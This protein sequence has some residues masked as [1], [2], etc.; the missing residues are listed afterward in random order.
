M[1]SVKEFIEKELL[2]KFKKINPNDTPLA[3]GIVFKKNDEQ[4]RTAAVI[5]LLYDCKIYGTELRKIKN[6]CVYKFVTIKKENPLLKKGSY[7]IAL[8]QSKFGEE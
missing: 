4:S 5:K 2:E 3:W 1:K 6:E 7:L 8:L